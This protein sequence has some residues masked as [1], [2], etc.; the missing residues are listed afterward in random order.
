MNIIA[1]F[2]IMSFPTDATEGQR[3]PLEGTPY[4]VF[5]NGGWKRKIDH[6]ELGGTTEDNLHSLN[7]INTLVAKLAT[8]FEALTIDTGVALWDIDTGSYKTLS[9]AD[10]FTLDIDNLVNGSIGTLLLE[11]TATSTITLD[12]GLFNKG[13]SLVDI[14]ANTYVLTF[15][16]DGTNFVYNIKDYVDNSE[17]VEGLKEFRVP[18]EDEWND[19]RLSWSSNDAAGAFASPLKLTMMGDRIFNNGSLSNVGSRGRYWCSTL[20]GAGS[21]YLGFDSGNALT[22]GIPRASGISVRLIKDE[23]YT[24]DAGDFVSEE[25]IIDGLTYN[26]VLNP[27]TNRIWLD[28]NLG[29]TQVATSSTDADAYGDLY[30]WGR[31]TDGHEKRDSDTTSTLSSTDQPGH[32]DFI[33]APDSPNDWR[34]LQNDNLWQGVD[35]INNPAK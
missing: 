34:D 18:T 17:V 23:V 25:I 8:D 6:T 12:T 14:E 10:S 11:V 24:G 22:G 28:R 20:S 21:R 13:D 3:H 1:H 4:W 26:T 35:G 27:D 2:K 16:C 30:Q 31:G 5:T 33:L 19:E 32:G 29:A 9:T 7:S 15:V